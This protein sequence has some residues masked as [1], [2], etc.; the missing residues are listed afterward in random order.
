M[1]RTLVLGRCTFRGEEEEERKRV[2]RIQDVG[3][4]K[5]LQTQ[6]ATGSETKKEDIKELIRKLVR[7]YT[8]TMVAEKQAVEAERRQFI[9]NVYALF[10]SEPTFA[11]ELIEMF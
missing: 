4:I 1:V 3:R 2:Q 6:L 11:N 7:N 10:H 8:A 9:E 5:L